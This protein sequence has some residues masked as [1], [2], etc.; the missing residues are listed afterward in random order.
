MLL[1]TIIA[2]FLPAYSIAIAAIFDAGCLRFDAAAFRRCFAAVERHIAP[3][4]DAMPSCRCFTIFRRLAI[5]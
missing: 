4:A 5:C 2:F 3:D 1:L